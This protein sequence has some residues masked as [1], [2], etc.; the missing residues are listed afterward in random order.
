LAGYTKNEFNSLR[1]LLTERKAPRRKTPTSISHPSLGRRG[2]DK[3]EPFGTKASTLV[4]EI[5]SG[6]GG[7]RDGSERGKTAKITGHLENSV[8]NSPSR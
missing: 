5:G 7:G 6:G 8:A 3:S 1:N 2:K 4:L